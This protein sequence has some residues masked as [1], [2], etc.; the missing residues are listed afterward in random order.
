MLDVIE[1]IKKYGLINSQLLT[2]AP[3]GSLSSMLQVTGGIEPI[4]ATHYTRKTESL[5]NEERTNSLYW[6]D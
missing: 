5:H 2:C 4:F 3:T 1:L 6:K